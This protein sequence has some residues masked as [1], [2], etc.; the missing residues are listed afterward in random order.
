MIRILGGGGG[1]GGLLP[2]DQT[3]TLSYNIL[4]G[5][6]TPF[7]IPS[8]DK[9]YPFHIPCLELCNPFDCYKCTVIL[10][11]INHKNRKFSRL[12]KAMDFIC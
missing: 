12:Y 6:G 1:G 7:R 10:I 2:E 11:R 9:W 3:L 5:K 8:I 4:D